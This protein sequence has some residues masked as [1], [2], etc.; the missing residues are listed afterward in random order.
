MMRTG[1]LQQLE[2]RFRRKTSLDTAT[3]DHTTTRAFNDAAALNND[4]GVEGG[5]L[6]LLRST[7]TGHGVC[8]KRRRE[9]DAADVA[10][11]RP[12]THVVAAFTTPSMGIGIY[13]SDDSAPRAQIVRSTEKDIL[14]VQVLPCGAKDQTTNTLDVK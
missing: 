12:A 3:I 1:L 13:C 2:G 11:R 14:V 7:P 10:A 4:V 5:V 8:R 6:G 9:G